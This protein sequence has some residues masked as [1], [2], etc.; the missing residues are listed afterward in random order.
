[1]TDYTIYLILNLNKI[2]NIETIKCLV[3]DAANSSNCES[4]YF[5]HETEGINNKILKNNIIYVINFTDI[6]NLINYIE[7]IK[8]LREIEIETIYNNDNIIYGSKKYIKTLDK[9]FIDPIIIENNISKN[10]VNPQY[11]QIFKSL[12]KN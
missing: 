4:E 6:I 5:T 8:T 1:M 9:N 3:K 2:K 12:S 7:F 10:K 11:K